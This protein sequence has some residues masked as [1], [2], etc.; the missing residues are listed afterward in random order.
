MKTNT[1]PPSAAGRCLLSSR[2]LF[3]VLKHNSLKCTCSPNMYTAGRERSVLTVKDAL[4][5]R[6]FPVHCAFHFRTPNA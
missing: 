2:H 5:S 6:Y 3:V 1:N 4:C